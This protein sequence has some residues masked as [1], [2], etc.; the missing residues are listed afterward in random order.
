L[1]QTIDKNDNLVN[2]KNAVIE[3]SITEELFGDNI[4]R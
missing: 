4:E 2:V 3:E 1:T